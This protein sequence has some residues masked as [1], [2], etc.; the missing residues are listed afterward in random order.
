[1]TAPAV[2]KDRRPAHAAIRVAATLATALALGGCLGGP[3]PAPTPTRPP[4]VSASPVVTVYDLDTAVWAEGFVITFHTATASLD[5]KGGPVVVSTGIDN[6]GT[7]AATLEAPIRLT[8]SG[9][10]FELARGTELPEI[11]GGG[12]ADVSLQFEIVGRPSIDDGVLRIGRSAD[13][14]ARVPLAPGPIEP[15]TLEPEKLRVSGSGSS[16]SF[17]VT[18]RAGEV[19]WDLPDWHDELPSGIEALTLTYDVTYLGTFSGGAPFTAENIALRLPDGRLVAPRRDGH[20]QTVVLIGPLKTVKG[21]ISRFEVP[22]AMTGR[23]VLIVKQGST[24]HGELAFTI[25]P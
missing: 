17:E 20:S 12:H 2:Q 9:A 22:S 7:D 10:V 1:L 21:V 4:I 15:L 25:A 3:T 5:A 13:H 24:G 14:Q 16:P 8:A 19:R 6:A 11:D 23:F 18:F